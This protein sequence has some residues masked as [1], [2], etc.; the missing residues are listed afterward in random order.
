M[1]AIGMLKYAT[2]IRG[3]P[4]VGHGLGTRSTFRSFRADLQDAAFLGRDGAHLQIGFFDQ[5]M[6]NRGILAMK[7]GRRIRTRLRDA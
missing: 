2:H 7:R 4:S 5:M 1:P 3:R 6:A